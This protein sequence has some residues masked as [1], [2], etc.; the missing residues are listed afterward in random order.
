M[1]TIRCPRLGIAPCTPAEFSERINEITEFPDTKRTPAEERLDLTI[2]C[3]IVAL[4][5]EA[6][7]AWVPDGRLRMHSDRGILI[8]GTANGSVSLEEVQEAQEVHE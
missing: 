8:L 7:C 2:L 1:I 5:G 6:S 4:G 3:C